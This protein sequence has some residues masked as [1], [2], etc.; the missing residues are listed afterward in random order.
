MSNEFVVRVKNPTKTDSSIT[1][2]IRIDRELQ[3][4]HDELS[5]KSGHS[6]NE[7]MTM[8][9]KYAI[10]NLRFVEEK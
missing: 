4:K 2:T 8:A 7:L 5:A 3:Q 9:L 1:M 10:D 6:R